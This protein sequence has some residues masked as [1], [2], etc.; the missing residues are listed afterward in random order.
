M[1][2][3]TKRGARRRYNAIVNACYRDARGGTQY[4]ID[5]P[6]LYATWPDRAAEIKAL[7]AAYP[8]LP[9]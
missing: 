3:R 6:T 4:G 5:W 2:I 7:K 8:N 9:E 1:T